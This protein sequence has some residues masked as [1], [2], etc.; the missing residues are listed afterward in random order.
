MCIWYN[1]YFKLNG[2]Y[3]PEIRYQKETM[4]ASQLYITNLISFIEDPTGEKY[5]AHF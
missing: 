2:T 5:G 3:N 4:T 1:Q